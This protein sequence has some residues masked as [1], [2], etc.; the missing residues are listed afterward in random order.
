MG[1]T[2]QGGGRGAG[3]NSAARS[4]GPS[5]GGDRQA[6]RFLGRHLPGRVPDRREHL[7]ASGKPE[8]L[9]KFDRA[10]LKHRDV[11]ETGLVQFSADS[12]RVV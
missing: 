10:R 2:A 5:H 1:V 3:K 9:A 7:V 8:S 12:G 4:F 6:D 11:I